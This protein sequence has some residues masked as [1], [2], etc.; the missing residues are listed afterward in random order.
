LQPKPYLLFDAGGTLVFP[1]QSFLIQQAQT[2]GLQLSHEQLF[3][4]HCQ[5]IYDLDRYAD[6]HGQLPPVWPQGYV[7]ALLEKLGLTGPAVKAIDQASQ[8]RNRH[9]SL[10]AFTFDWMSEALSQLARHGYQMSVISN[11]DG[12]A[13]DTLAAVGLDHYFE[14]IFDSTLLGVEKPDPAIFKIALR[15]LNLLPAEALYIGDVYHIDVAGAN[16]AGLGC[17]HLDPLGL[18]AAW[19]GVHLPDVRHLPAW[20][21]R[22]EANPVAYDLFPTQSN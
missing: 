12:R 2:Y 13:R 21:A 9:Q 20:L 15:E 4:G 18:Y 19:P 6:E 7:L 11:S 14:Q 1:D 10:W 5:L 8:A 16:R 3:I 17:L 22:Y